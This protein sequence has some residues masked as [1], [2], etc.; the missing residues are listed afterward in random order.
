M[1]NEKVLYKH[2][3]SFVYNYI[4]NLYKIEVENNNNT[5][6]EE[7]EISM[8][9]E[10]K[11]PSHKDKLKEN[12][13]IDIKNKYPHLLNLYVNKIS[14]DIFE[15]DNYNKGILYEKICVNKLYKK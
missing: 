10:D 4:N 7:F 3:E 14:V 6:L 9:I 1:D 11:Y 12:L 8:F 13:L 15:D 2:I 5:E